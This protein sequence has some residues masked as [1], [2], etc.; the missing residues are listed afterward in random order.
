MSLIG[1]ISIYFFI[2]LYGIQVMKG[3]IEEKN[4]RIIEVMVSSVRPFQLMI[5]KILGMALLALT[6]FG[7]WL[8]VFI[9]GY[10]FTYNQLGLK[11]FANASAI[12]KV[13]EAGTMSLSNAVSIHEFVSTMDEMNVPQVLGGFIFFFLMG[14]LIYGALFAIVGAASDVDTETQQFIM[15]ITVPLLSTMV[16]VSQMTSNPHSGIAKFLSFFP[17]TSPLAMTARLPFAD[18]AS[19][20]TLE[21][22]LSM[23]LAIAGFIGIVF[24]AS[25][26]YRI[27]ILSYGS[28]VGYKDLIKWFFVKE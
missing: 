9:G 17:L 24:I 19:S 27:G 4:N 15:P 18:T 16:F 3:V 14:Y 11:N 6:Q 10:S 2:F 28:K 13:T 7:V 25:R 26:I 5:G 8:I 22:I 20:F 21:L 12:Q 1:A 23:L